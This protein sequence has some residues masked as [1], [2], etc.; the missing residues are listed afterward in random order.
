L[1]GFEQSRRR[2]GLSSTTWQA[3]EP[4]HTLAFTHQ[5]SHDRFGELATLPLP[6]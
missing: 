3:T 4:A 2:H 5:P 6:D 1:I